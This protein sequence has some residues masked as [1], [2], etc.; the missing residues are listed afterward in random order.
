MK[1][2]VSKAFASFINKTAKEMGFNVAA[3]V[4]QMSANQYKWNVDLDLFHAEDF[5]DYDFTTGMFK[6]ICLTYPANYYANP[7]YLTTYALNREFKRNNIT[8]V[9]GLKQMVKTMCEI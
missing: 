9:E 6:A 7:Q 1:I 8:S 4:V 2:K 3:K 5:G